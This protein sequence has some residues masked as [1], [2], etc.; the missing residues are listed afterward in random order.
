MPSP[1]DAYFGVG[2]GGV[3]FSAFSTSVVMS[4]PP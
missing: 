3:I 2:D 1:S 4:S